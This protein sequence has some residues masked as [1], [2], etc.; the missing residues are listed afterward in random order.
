VENVVFSSS[1]KSSVCVC[2]SE[3]D[4][5]MRIVGEAGLR[6]LNNVSMREQVLA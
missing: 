6:G 4:V 2:G 3:E 5:A 1:R